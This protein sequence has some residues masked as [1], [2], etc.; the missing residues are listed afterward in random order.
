MKRRHFLKSTAAALVAAQT[1][2]IFGGRPAHAD[3]GSS[4][5]PRLKMPPLLDTRETGRLSLSARAGALSLAGGPATATT[6]F[7]QDY[8]GPTIIMQ[9]GSLAANVE[10]TLDEAISVHWHGLLVPGEHDGGPHLPISPGQSWTPDMSIAQQPATAWYH[11]HIHGRTAEQVYS[12]LA[13]VIHVTDGHDAE[14]G[15]PVDYGVDD[16]TLVL[17]DRRISPS[18]QMVYDPSMMDV[19]HGFMGNRMLVN[20]QVGAVAAVPAGIVRLRL[21]N[22][23]NARSYRLAFDDGRPMHMIATDGGFLP[24]SVTLD[25]LTLSPGE[26]VEILVDFATGAA[27]VLRSGFEQPF[28]VLEFAIDDTLPARITSHPEGFGPELEVLTGTQVRTRTLSL[29]MGMG[30]MM[31]GAGGFAINQRPF[32]MDRIDL[33]VELGSVEKWVVSSTMIAHPFHVHGALFRVVSENG[34]PPRPENLGWKDTV[35]VRDQAEIIMR[36]DQPASRDKPFM[37]HCHILEHEDAGMM[38]QFTVS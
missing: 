5:R 9:N 29:D 24:G 1:G 14:R 4:S 36:F 31:G 37:Y 6:G 17:Q 18:G 35:L 34:S 38:G 7:S 30:G 8:L 10:N 27:P 20:G 23:S 15:L 21:L 13:G 28:G 26:R 2:S 33:E 16:L 25:G 11:S 32:A 22:G 12:G 3:A 19:M